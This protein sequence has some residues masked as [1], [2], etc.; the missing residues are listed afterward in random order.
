MHLKATPKQVLLIEDNPAD[1]R[2]IELLLL[3]ATGEEFTLIWIDRLQPALQLLKQQQ[4][5]D[6]VLLDL[7]L[8]DSEGLQTF[9]RSHEVAP[10][11]PFILLTGLDD[12]E[13]GVTAVHAGAQDYLVKGEVD[14]SLL[15]RA[16]RY[17]IERQRA[18]NA[19]RAS[20]SRYRM[21]MEQA[22]D[23]ILICDEHGLLSEANNRACEIVGYSQA[24]LTTLRLIDLLAYYDKELLRRNLEQ[25]RAGKTIVE[26]MTLQHHDQYEITVESSAKQLEDGSIQLI[27]RDVTERNFL[28][29]QILETSEQERQ[30]IGQDLHDALGQT[31]T[32]V[33]FLCKVLAQRLRAQNLPEAEQ[34]DE[35]ARLMNESIRQT[36]NLARGLCPVEVESL[37]LTGA[38]E[39]YAGQIESMFNV[40]C[41]A[42]GNDDVKFAD[43]SVA[44]HLY[45]IAQEAAGNA[46]RH[47]K[48]KHISIDLRQEGDR[49][50]LGIEDD[51]KG[52]NNE[53]ASDGMGLNIMSYRARK[54][55]ATFSIRSGDHCGTIV[56]VTLR[57]D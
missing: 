3:E 28:E 30:R 14:S 20:E 4:D 29:R 55:G 18:E 57:H 39:S 26:D 7:R 6:V 37:G 13:L 17:G 52:F 48:A 10:N 36:R 32:G 54:I 47:G 11:T 12:Q 24:E 19:R 46:I 50:I 53:P 42:H 56:E 1:A 34:A 51:G 35:L 44:T 23:G 41:T 8:P 38:L 2:L 21:L 22:S 9:L 15:V 43:T 25:M 16:I 5:I 33:A 45:R 40:Q 27:I 49:I 31:L